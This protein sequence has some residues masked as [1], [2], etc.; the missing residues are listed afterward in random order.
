MSKT[1]DIGSSEP[2]DEVY[3][4]QMMD[5]K[6]QRKPMPPMPPMQGTEDIGSSEH[7]DEG[8]TPYGSGDTLNKLGA[9]KVYGGK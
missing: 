5:P 1:V 2:D 4:P 3:T 9:G 6:P 7:D 8:Y